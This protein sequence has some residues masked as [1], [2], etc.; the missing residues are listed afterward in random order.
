[1]VIRNDVRLENNYRNGDGYG[2]FAEIR[3]RIYR[4][5]PLN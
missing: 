1:M 4:Y 2:K 5:C 3:K